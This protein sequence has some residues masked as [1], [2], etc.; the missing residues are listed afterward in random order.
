MALHIY[1]IDSK[2]EAGKRHARL[3][4]LGWKSENATTNLFSRRMTCS[5]FIF[6]REETDDRQTPPKMTSVPA[7]GSVHTDLVCCLTGY[8]YTGHFKNFLTLA[9]KTSSVI[10]L[11][12]CKEGQTRL[13]FVCLTVS[14]WRPGK[15]WLPQ[16]C[17]VTRTAGWVAWWRPQYSQTVSCSLPP[18]DSQ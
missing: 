15:D 1:R 13:W 18:V 5:H 6:L 9:A 11:T 17:R 8:I 12:S 14:H 10:L 7:T 2:R 4:Q 16:M 3:R